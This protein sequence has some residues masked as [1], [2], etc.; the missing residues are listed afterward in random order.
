M[1][2]IAEQS[3]LA[4]EKTAAERREKEKKRREARAA[5]LKAIIAKNEKEQEQEKDQELCVKD[6]RRGNNNWK[7]GRLPRCAT[8]A[9]TNT[10]PK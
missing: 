10:K 6:R 1:E 5:K 4:A 3:K 8:S 9:R 7:R 2:W